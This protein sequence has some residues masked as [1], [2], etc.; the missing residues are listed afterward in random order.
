[1]VVHVNEVMLLS[2]LAKKG[3]PVIAYSPLKTVRGSFSCAVYC[4]DKQY[5][6]FVLKVSFPLL[7]AL[8]LLAI[9][10]VVNLC[11]PLTLQC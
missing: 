7:Q 5:D 8:N 9:P 3:A 11:A 2:S 6:Q 10:V 1:M 4:V